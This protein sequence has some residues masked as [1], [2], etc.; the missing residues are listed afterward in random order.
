MNWSV[1]M[2]VGFFLPQFGPAAEPW[3][4]VAVAKRA[5]E[6]AYDS[7]WVTDRFRWPL[8]PQAAYTDAPCGALP[9]A[10][11]YVLDPLETLTFV[12]AHTTRITLGTSVLNVASYHP[13]D[14]ARRLATLDVFSGGR[15]R[16]GLGLGGTRDEYDVTGIASAKYRSRRADEFLRVLKIIWTTDPVEFDGEFFRIP[17]SV[18]GLKP[19]Q[20][21]H[22]PMYLGGWV[23]AGMRR[24]VACIDGWHLTAGRSSSITLPR[25]IEG[26]K[27]RAQEA[28]RDPGTMS[29][30]LRAFVT[31]TPARGAGRAPFTGSLDEIRRDVD[32][33]RAAGVDELLFDPTF[34]PVGQMGE[35]FLHY[36]EQLRPL[37]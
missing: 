27:Q 10:Y 37:V 17:P 20:R 34:S 6:L 18:V 28:G 11:R 21:P 25:M 36:L 16:A 22:P 5:E 12:A 4:N 7:V 31:I 8:G 2:R 13:M 35:G 32:T 26:L 15:L 1:E 24:G 9:D 33:V 19:V 3:A 14:L 29:V 30:V 23:P